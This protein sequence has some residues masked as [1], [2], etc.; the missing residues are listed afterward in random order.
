METHVVILGTSD[1]HGNICC[2][3][4]GDNAETDYG[5]A[6]LYTCIRETREENPVT[7]LIDGGDEIQGNLLTDSIA[8]RNPDEPNP[9]I[10]AMNAMSYDSM[11]LGNHEFDWGVPDMLKMLSTAEFPLLAQNVT[12]EYGKLLT[13][14]GW[15]ILERGGIRLG[16]IGVV[17]PDVPI[18][19]SGREGV[20]ALSFEDASKAVKKAIS[21][22]GDQADIIMVSAHMGMTG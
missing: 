22:I 15:T 11:T 17:T 19:E 4:Y 14:K 8:S 3:S 5:M 12:G 21:E 1:M 2:W 18:L 10:E 9:V 7:F 20:S 13:G 6:R 16:V